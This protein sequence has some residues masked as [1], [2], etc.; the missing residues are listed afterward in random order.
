MTK[1]TC[2]TD[3]CDRSVRA[4][5]MCQKHYAIVWRAERF[6][7]ELRCSVEDCDR[8]DVVTFGLCRKHYHRDWRAKQAEKPCTVEGCVRFVT[9]AGLC[10]MH[11]QRLQKWG[12]LGPPGSVLNL[13]GEGYVG[14]NG[15]RMISI[16]GTRVAEHRLVMERN[17]GRALWP[18]ENVHHIN[19][20]R[21]DNRITNLE[22]W[23][24]SQP[25]GQRVEDKADWAVE[26]LRRYR[27]DALK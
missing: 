21:A 20:D 2:S 9:S 5:G 17:L 25:P 6:A 15:Y 24:S 16:N 26:I 23:S 8:S 3:G 18:D 12:H 13:S 4:R 1:A 27:P 22:L 11:L 19:G 10:S 14:P 7:G